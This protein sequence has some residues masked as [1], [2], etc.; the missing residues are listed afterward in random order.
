MSDTPFDLA[1]CGSPDTALGVLSC[2]D[3]VPVE[4]PHRVKGWLGEAQVLAWTILA[5]V[6]LLATLATAFDSV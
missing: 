3:P 5:V 2:G 6:A 4:S 1:G